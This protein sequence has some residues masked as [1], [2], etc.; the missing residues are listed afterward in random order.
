MTLADPVNGAEPEWEEDW[1]FRGR[2]IGRGAPGS[3]ERVISDWSPARCGI[4]TPLAQELP[5]YLGWPKIEQPPEEASLQAMYLRQDGL[6]VVH[7]GE[8][9]C[10][11][12]ICNDP[13]NDTCFPDIDA[14]Q[15]CPCGE[16]RDALAG[17]TNFV[18]YRQERQGL[19]AASEFYQVSPHVPSAYCE[20]VNGLSQL[21]DPLIKVSMFGGLPAPWNA[22]GLMYVDRYPSV[23][24]TDYRYQFVYFDSAGEIVRYRTSNWITAE[25]AP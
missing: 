2:T 4:R 10:S 1:C 16:V 7:L 6:P 24:N 17:E 23:E 20:E 22:P 21:E 25:A 15:S 12:I 11:A 3:E 19:G 5:D 13:Q 8:L 14:P 18:A 9:I